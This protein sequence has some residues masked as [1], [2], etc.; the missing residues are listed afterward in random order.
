MELIAGG[1]PAAPGRNGG[2]DVLQES[3][4]EVFLASLFNGADCKINAI[5]NPLSPTGSSRSVCASSHWSNR[6]RGVAVIATILL[7][8]VES[9]APS[10]GLS[11]V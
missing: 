8:A 7:S 10:F 1:T 3:E 9:R 2:N 11:R 5:V 4:V 6:G